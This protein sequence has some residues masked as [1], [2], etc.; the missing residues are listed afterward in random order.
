MEARKKIKK[1]SN[2][3]TQKQSGNLCGICFIDIYHKLNE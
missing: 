3:T 2:K 1:I